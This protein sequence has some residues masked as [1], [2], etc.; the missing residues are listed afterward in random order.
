MLGSLVD[1]VLARVPCG[2]SPWRQAS[3]SRHPL[4]S[5]G[6]LLWAS[7]L[8]CHQHTRD[9]LPLL[10][11]FTNQR[12]EFEGTRESILVWLTEMDL[13]LTNVEHFS[14]SDADDKMRQLNVSL[15]PSAPRKGMQLP[16]RRRRAAKY[17]FH[18][19]ASGQTPELGK[20]PGCLHLH[21]GCSSTKILFPAAQGSV[22]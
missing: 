17:S 12:E 3:E 10:Q 8:R 22:E 15:P 19:I 2:P 21:S 1:V 5:A 20:L 4:P 14:E 9:S 6:T 7:I 16:A 11:H 18:L 13:Q